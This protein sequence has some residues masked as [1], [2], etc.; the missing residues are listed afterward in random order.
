M[1]GQKGSKGGHIASLHGLHGACHHQV[2]CAHGTCRS[3]LYGDGYDVMTGYFSGLINAQ[4]AYQFLTPVLAVT[5]SGPQVTVS[6]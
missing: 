4:Y 6:C 1:E 5:G 2:L 3:Y